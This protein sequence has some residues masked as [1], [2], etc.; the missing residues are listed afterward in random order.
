MIDSLIKKCFYCFS[1][2]ELVSQLQCNFLSKMIY[3]I[4]MS[5][6]KLLINMI[7]LFIVFWLNIIQSITFKIR[8]IALFRVLKGGDYRLD[9]K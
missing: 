5:L 4:Y 1:W 9:D 8:L 3:H 7:M 2:L 6:N